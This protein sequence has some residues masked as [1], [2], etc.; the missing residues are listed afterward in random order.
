LRRLAWALLREKAGCVVARVLG[1]DE[2]VGNWSLVG[3]GLRRGPT[4]LGFA[5]LLLRFYA[6]HGRL[7]L[8]PAS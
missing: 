7:T 3:A 6:L 1:E 2:L 8:R 5:L 4:K